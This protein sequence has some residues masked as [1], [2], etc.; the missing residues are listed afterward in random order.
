MNLKIYLTVKKIR[1]IFKKEYD[2]IT[3]RKSKVPKLVSTLTDKKEYI[4]HANLLEF[5][6]RQGS[7]I[8]PIQIL[9][10]NEKPWM[11]TFIEFNIDKRI[12]AKNDFEID[13]FKLMNNS[14]KVKQWKM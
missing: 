3:L 1:T 10:F 6:C 2:N 9:T 4:V 14:I 8:K 12:K 7:I 13:F 11:K 5:Y